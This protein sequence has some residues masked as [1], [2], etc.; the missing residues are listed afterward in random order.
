[1]RRGP[2]SPHPHQHLLLDV[3]MT[4]IQRVWHN[5]SLWF[6]FSFSWWLVMFIIF[7][8]VRWPSVR[9]FGRNADWG[10]QPIFLIRLFE[11][12]CVCVCVKLY[13]FYICLDSN[14]LSDVSFVNILSHSVSCLLVSF[15]LPCKNFLDWCGPIC[16]F[17]LLFPL[18]KETY[19]KDNTKSNVKE[20]TAYVFF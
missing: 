17:F 4:A 1:M 15:P 13:E 12:L 2:F 16:L 19:P 11:G 18:L 10:P 6:E 7:S 9:P 8:H 5:I 3:L 20:F 14:P